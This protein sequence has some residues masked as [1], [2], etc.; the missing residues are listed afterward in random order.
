[1][2][3][4]RRQAISVGVARLLS[5][6][7]IWT[8]APC[9]LGADAQRFVISQANPQ[10][11]VMTGY[12]D[13]VDAGAQPVDGLAPA[14][15]A[16]TLGT[17]ALE[18]KDLQLFEQTGEGVSYVF[19]VD[20]SK[21]MSTVQFNELREAIKSW[22]G[23]LK[24]VDRAAIGTFGDD[25]TMVVD[26]T[27]DQ[28]KLKAAVDGLAPRDKQT[29]LYKA[30]DRAVELQ[31]RV[32]AGLPFRRVIVVL[33]DGRDEGSAITADDVLL[34][35]RASRLP[36]YSIGL[37]HQPKRE[38]QKYLDVLQRF[39]NVSGGVYHEAAAETIPQLY[40]SLRQAILRVFVAHLAC[41]SCLADGRSWPLEITLTQ[42]ARGF[43]AAPLEVIPLAGPVD[44]LPTPPAPWWKRVPW[45]GWT[46]ILVTLVAAGVALALRSGEE[47]EGK[48]EGFYLIEDTGIDTEKDREKDKKRSDHVPITGA[49][50]AGR[51][52]K[53]TVVVGENAG[54]AHS[55]KLLKTAVIGRDTDCDVVVHDP[56]VANRHCE[57]ALIHGQILVYDLGS[58]GNTWVNGVP[59]RG[60]HKLQP[61]DVIQVGD[62]ELRVHFEEQ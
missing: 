43:K 10:L 40:A 9:V 62:T 47:Q 57:L 17:T 15:F 2:R 6:L 61:L 1:M 42:G 55:M 34:K 59:I 21:S 39:C 36:V 3:K 12:L 35:L 24:P 45:W 54:S 14:N 27:A 32:D 31:Q 16:A 19:L 22:I 23:L 8:A 46:A 51:A 56:G 5:I 20:I 49:D 7:A 41:R 4:L 28:D 26:F 37:S 38:R 13:I 18:V 29:R 25:Y 33:S 53:L 11:P 48:S 58:K 60:R 44:P 30:I 52:M 50:K